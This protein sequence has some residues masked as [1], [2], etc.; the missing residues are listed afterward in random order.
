LPQQIPLVIPEVEGNV[1]TNST[2]SNAIPAQAILELAW[3]KLAN[4]SRVINY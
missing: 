3:G 1:Q 4:L 2:D